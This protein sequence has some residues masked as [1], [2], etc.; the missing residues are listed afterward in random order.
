MN[1]A[2]CFPVFK[3]HVALG[4]L[5][6]FTSGPRDG[7]AMVTSMVIRCSTRAKNIGC[8]SHYFRL[9]PDCGLHTVWLAQAD[10]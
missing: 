9:H 4:G 5:L 3:K 8:C 6:L 7:E 2:P 10:A 1:N